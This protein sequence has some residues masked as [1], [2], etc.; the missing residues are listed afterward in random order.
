MSRVPVVS[1]I[2]PTYNRADLLARAVD[3]ALA[4]TYQSAEIVVV[5]DGS[6]DDTTG[7]LRRYGNR[8]RCI[9]TS[10]RGPSHARNAGIRASRG[11]YLAFLDSDDM[12]YP[13]K[14]E[15]QV[16]QMEAHPDLGMIYTDF[17]ALFPDGSLDECH[18][19]KYH[20]TYDRNGWRFEDVFSSRN[21]VSARYRGRVVTLYTGDIFDFVLRGTLVATTTMLIRRGVFDVVGYQNEAYRFAEDYEFVLRIC[22]RFRVG[23][24]DLP[25]YTVQYHEGQMSRFLT[26]DRAGRRREDVVLEIEGWQVLLRAILD[27]A[28]NDPVY[29]AAHRTAVDGRL[30]ELHKTIGYLWRDYGD[31]AKARESLRRAYVLEG[32]RLRSLRSWLVPRLPPGV[33]RAVGVARGAR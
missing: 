25:T 2:V 22:K 23:F 7:V 33:M 10:H 30:A 6:T 15:V 14:L 27:W 4:Q 13:Y 19:R 20:G 24:L 11:E 1:V 16:A 8:I 5:D 9:E 31:P 12:Y 29:Y 32:K 17:S 26:R 28:Y 3:S 21:E 18:L